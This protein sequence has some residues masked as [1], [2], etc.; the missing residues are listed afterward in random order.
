MNSLCTISLTFRI[1]REAHAIVDSVISLSES[2]PH[3]DVAVR[4]SLSAPLT[5]FPGSSSSWS[6]D[7]PTPA[8]LDVRLV[9]G[10]FE[11]PLPE[12]PLVWRRQR[13]NSLPNVWR[14]VRSRTIRNTNIKRPCKLLKMQKRNCIT[15]AA[16]PMAKIANTHV[17]PEH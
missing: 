10:V 5:S 16:G 9:S 13:P 1:R 6:S 15:V 17:R 8:G 2:A 11:S 14:T 3:R 4:D 7:V 12:V